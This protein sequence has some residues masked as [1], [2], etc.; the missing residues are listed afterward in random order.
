[1]DPLSLYKLLIAEKT[2]KHVVFCCCIF[3]IMWFMMKVITGPL[4]AYGCFFLGMRF[5]EIIIKSPRVTNATLCRRCSFKIT[6]P[7]RDCD[8]LRQIRSPKHRLHGFRW[9]VN[10]IYKWMW[11]PVDKWR[12]QISS[13]KLVSEGSIPSPVV[14]ARAFLTWQSLETMA[15]REQSRHSSAVT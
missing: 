5:G 1:M 7:F 11:G 9:M 3:C 8:W 2:R 13:A 14:L 12:F 4:A 6:F 10:R 15:K